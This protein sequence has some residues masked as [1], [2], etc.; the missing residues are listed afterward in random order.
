MLIFFIWEVLNLEQ[1]TSRAWRKFLSFLLTSETPRSPGVLV[2][3]ILS[4]MNRKKIQAMGLLLK[5]KVEQHK[6]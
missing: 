1:G 5:L 4:Q 3:I 6:L 2:Q